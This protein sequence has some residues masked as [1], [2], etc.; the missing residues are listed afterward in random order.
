[1][2]FDELKEQLLVLM[3]EAI[4]DEEFSTGELMIATGLIVQRDGTVKKMEVMS[5]VF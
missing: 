3:P 4:F 5:D 1:M 2:T